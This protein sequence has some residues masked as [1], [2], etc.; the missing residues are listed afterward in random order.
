M[1]RPE[2][3]EL[4]LWRVAVVLVCTACGSGSPT[5][6]EP[7]QFSLT[8]T[9]IDALSRGGIS[10]SV[11]LLSMAGTVTIAARTT[12]PSGQFT[13][14]TVPASSYVLRAS[15]SG[16]EPSSQTIHLTANTTVEIGLSRPA[17]TALMIAD[18][19]NGTDNFC[20]SNGTSSSNVSLVN[21]TGYS[22]DV[23]FTGGYQ[24]DPAT[25][26]VAYN[27]TLPPSDTRVFTV[28]PGSYESSGQSADGRAVLEKAG[29]VFSRGCD[30][31]HAICAQNNNRACRLGSPP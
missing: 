23:T 5:S 14:G 8:G 6:P 13:F 15:A 2:E 3:P 7:T 25:R 11:D 28:T 21:G 31:A 29:W 12:D 10:A 30:V 17:V 19:G 22:V 4:R 18:P 16:Y 9:V 24:G 1:T 27:V 26:G 20:K